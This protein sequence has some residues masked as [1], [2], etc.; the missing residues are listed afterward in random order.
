LKS[1]QRNISE[2]CEID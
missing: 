2:Y 1:K